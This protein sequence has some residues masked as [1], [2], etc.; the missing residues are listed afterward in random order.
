MSTP[1]ST[2]PG[3][4]GPPADT[5]RPLT[6]LALVGLGFAIPSLLVF[7]LNQE[8]VLV[9]LGG[10]GLLISLYAR[11]LV[12]RS[13]GTL[14]GAGIAGVGLA[15]SLVSLLGW[16]TKRGVEYWIVSSESRSFVDGFLKKF[17]DDTEGKYAFLD[18]VPA[19]GRTLPP[20]VNLAAPDGLI[21]LRKHFPAPDGAGSVFDAFRQD[22]L[23]ATLLRY[24]DQVEWTPKGVVAWRYNQSQ[25]KY[26]MEHR[27]RMRT[28]ELTTDVVLVAVS[29]LVRDDSG[30]WRREWRIEGSGSSRMTH[31]TLTDYGKEM[32]DAR[33]EAQTGF[34]KWM[35]HVVFGQKDEAL[36]MTVADDPSKFESLYEKARGDTPVGQKAAGGARNLLLLKDEKQGKHWLFTYVVMAE[37]QR[38]DMHFKVTLKGDPAGKPED[39][40]VLNPELTRFDRRDPQGMRPPGQD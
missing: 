18:T 25:A 23:W 4:L 5:Y 8:W 32:D 28:P 30:G 13:E 9:F 33:R 40:R 19:I 35:H 3:S 34:Q 2:A 31:P 26:T 37:T 20:H 6:P 1:A 22:F 39:W 14:S 24:G 7:V 21:Q 29:E 15:I 27:Y 11:R 12:L 16:S 10:P 17:A 38:H 36:A